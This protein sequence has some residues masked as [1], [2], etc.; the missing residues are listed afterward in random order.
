MNPKS[1]TVALMG[2]V[3]SSA[4]NAYDASLAA[5][6]DGFY[7]KFDHQALADSKLLM[8]P[9]EFYKEIYAKDKDYFILDVRTD[10]E[11]DMVNFTM[12]NS[13][14]VSLDKLFSK[15]SLDQLPRDKKIIVACRSGARSLLAAVN[16][17]QLGFKDVHSLK[18]GIAAFA[19]VTAPKTTLKLKN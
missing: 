11:A 6:L 12:P 7:K 4:V 1:V 16:L 18:G 15:A 10:A 13:S 17:K 14:H 2:L 8:E 5:T 19:D 3:L 9:E